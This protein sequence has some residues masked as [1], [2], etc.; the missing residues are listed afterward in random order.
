ML[1]PWT[2]T[3]MLT[4]RLIVCEKTAFWADA[5]RRET[6]LAVHETR[7]LAECWRELSDWPNS[8]LVLELTGGNG[9]MLISRLSDLGR[10]F[11]GAA[12]V[13]VTERRWHGYEW[14][15]REAGAVHFA[16]SPRCMGLVAR[17]ARRHLA[18]VPEKE[19]SP[20]QKI[21]ASLPW[22]EGADLA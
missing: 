3:D 11:S 9:E 19:M 1:W 8:L 6:D 18:A 21:W 20:V 22:P 14:I 4:A 15:V 5:L 12:A 2:D 7:S 16:V 13:V 10:E 17:L